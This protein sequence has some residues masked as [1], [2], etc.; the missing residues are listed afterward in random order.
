MTKNAVTQ[1]DQEGSTQSTSEGDPLLD[2]VHTW[3]CEQSPER[4]G[5]CPAHGLTDMAHRFRRDGNAPHTVQ[6]LGVAQTRLGASGFSGDAAVV[7]PQFGTCVSDSVE[8]GRFL[9]ETVLRLDFH[10][11]EAAVGK[12]HEDIGKRPATLSLEHVVDGHGLHPVAPE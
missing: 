9:V 5:F 11:A 3:E 2:A 1:V 6:Q 7:D 12:P 4:F 8:L 10:N